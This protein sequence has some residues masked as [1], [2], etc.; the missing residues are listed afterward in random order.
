MYIPDAHCS[1]VD[2]I[3][4]RNPSYEILRGA[5]EK[6]MNL[7]VSKGDFVFIK[8]ELGVNVNI[9]GVAIEVT[10]NMGFVAQQ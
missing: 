10:I 8:Q 7:L 9:G 5:S 3:H 4:F 1:T 6:G 2:D